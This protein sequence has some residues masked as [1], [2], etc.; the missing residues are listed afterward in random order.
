M[1]SDQKNANC[2]IAYVDN[3]ASTCKLRYIGLK[4]NETHARLS[5]FAAIISIGMHL[6]TS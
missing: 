6:I 2:I 4:K 5:H 1:K 3:L